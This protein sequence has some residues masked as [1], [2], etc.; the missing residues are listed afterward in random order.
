M[1]WRRRSWPPAWRPGCH[2]C[3]SHPAQSAQHTRRH[4]MQA[5]NADK[6]RRH[7]HTTR[8]SVRHASA[9]VSC[10]LIAYTD[11][12]TRGYQ[13][14]VTWMAARASCMVASLAPGGSG[15]RCTCR[16]MHCVTAAAGRL[17][18]RKHR[19]TGCVH[20]SVRM[21][22]PNEL[23]RPLLLVAAAHQAVPCLCVQQACPQAR[24]LLTHGG[25]VSNTARVLLGRSSTTLTGT[26]CT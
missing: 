19:C 11:T 26:T 8:C 22:I 24:H 13:Q 16:T 20:I 7:R 1:P 17:A 23:P 6:K 18:P 4:T 3:A 10:H 14:P 9:C 12:Q 15:V 5:R 21:Q 2:S 25:V